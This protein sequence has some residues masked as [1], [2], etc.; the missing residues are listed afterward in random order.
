[1]ISLDIVTEPSDNPRRLGRFVYLYARYKSQA[2]VDSYLKALCSFLL[3]P[4]LA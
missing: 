4:G 2:T 3:P 1:M